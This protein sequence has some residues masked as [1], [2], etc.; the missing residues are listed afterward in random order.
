MSSSSNHMSVSGFLGAVL[1][2][3]QLLF[4]MQSLSSVLG[5]PYNL[6]NYRNAAGGGGKRSSGSGIDL[7]GPNTRMS[8]DGYMNQ[9]KRQLN[10]PD[11][12]NPGLPEPQQPLNPQGM[13]IAEG[14]ELR[15]IPADFF[16]GLD[17]KQSL[18]P[19]KQQPGLNN[20]QGNFIMLGLD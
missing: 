9:L 6:A 20:I 3:A 13:Q 4:S 5:S 18:F 1:L 16:G 15:P 19:R 10:Y 12:S 17:R 14:V 2:A 8:L 7:W 11:N